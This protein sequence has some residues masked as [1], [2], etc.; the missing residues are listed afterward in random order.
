MQPIEQTASGLGANSLQEARVSVW[1]YGVICFLGLIL[2]LIVL[3]LFNILS[4]I[5]VPYGLLAGLPVSIHFANLRFLRKYRRALDS[6]ELK[7]FAVS[8]GVAFY[9]CD[10]PFALVARIHSAGEHPIKTAATIIV[11]LLVDFLIVAA[12]VYGTVPWFSKR[13]L[14]ASPQQ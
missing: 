5:T 4:G 2:T 7:W 1:W 3:V 6:A 13:I 11:A 9:A 8:C 12:I 14:G 10:E